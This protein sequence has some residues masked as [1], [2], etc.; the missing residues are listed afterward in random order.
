MAKKK[1]LY[2]VSGLISILK[3]ARNLQL[4]PADFVT[5]ILEAYLSKSIT[6]D[7]LCARYPSKMKM[8]I[9]NLRCLPQ[10]DIETNK[11]IFKNE[12]ILADSLTDLIDSADTMPEEDFYH[13]VCQL[14]SDYLAK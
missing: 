3:K 11:K 14:V 13:S 2:N 10:S 1:T 9:H 12:Y 6:M 4:S 8:A 5:D 7:E